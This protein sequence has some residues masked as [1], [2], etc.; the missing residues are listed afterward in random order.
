MTS[1]TSSTTTRRAA[2]DADLVVGALVHKGN[3]PTVWRVWAVWDD[4]V[5]R[6]GGGRRASVVKATTATDPTRG[7]FYRAAEFTIAASEVSL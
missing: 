1:T 2:T 6:N 5:A 4:G 3:G 7:C